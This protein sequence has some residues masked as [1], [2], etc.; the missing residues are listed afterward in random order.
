M[1]RIGRW[2]GVAVLVGIAWPLACTQHHVEPPP[3]PATPVVRVRLLVGESAVTLRATTP[4]TV[5]TATESSPLRLKIA[6]G[7]PASIV[8]TETGWQIGGAPVPGRGE[9]TVSQTQDA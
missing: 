3:S 9:L 5:K 8:L 4:P 2:A 6:P 1:G 7:D